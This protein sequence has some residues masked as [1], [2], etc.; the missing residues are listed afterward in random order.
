MGSIFHPSGGAT[1]RLVEEFGPSGLYWSGREE[2][3]TMLSDHSLSEQF[4]ATI[5]NLKVQ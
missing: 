1:V 5:L 3:L 2:G 4:P